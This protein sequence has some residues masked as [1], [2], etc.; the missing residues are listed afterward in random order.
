MKGVTDDLIRLK[1]VLLTDSLKIPNGV[2]EAL[3]NDINGILNSYFELTNEGVKTEISVDEN[4]IYH[5]ALTARAIAAR[6]MKTI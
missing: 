2:I 6:K 1:R 5:V 3:K 4:G